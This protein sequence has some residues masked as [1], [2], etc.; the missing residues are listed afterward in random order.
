MTFRLIDYRSREKDESAPEVKHMKSFAVFS[1]ALILPFLLM[2]TVE[3]VSPTLSRPNF[4]VILVD[5]LGWRDCGYSGSEFYETPAINQL[6]KDSIQFTQA[7]AACPVCSPTRASIHTGKYPARLQT[8]EWFGGLQPQDVLNWNKAEPLQQHRLLPAKYRDFL[9]LEETTLAEALQEAGYDTFIAGK[10]HLGGSGSEPEK[11]G[12]RLNV[13]GY[14]K[15]WPVGGYF[16]PYNNP[17]LLDGPEGEHLPD[18]LS[19]ESIQFLQSATDAPFFLMLSFYSVHVP[20]E[21]PEEL[22]GK[23]EEKAE[24]AHHRGV[25]FA[26]EGESRC[27]QVQDNAVYASMVESVDTAI[28][29]VLRSVSDLGLEE[30]T[31]VFFLSDNGGLSTSEGFPTS[32]VPLRAGKGWLY[33]GGIRIPWLVKWPGV[34]SGGE[35]CNVPVI[36]NDLYPTVLEIA[37]L[38]LRPHQHVDACSLVPLLKDQGELTRT[39]LYW[40]YPHYSNQGGPPGGAIR[41]ADWKLIE[42]FETNRLELYNLRDDISEQKN[43]AESESD[44]VRAMHSKLQHWRKSVNAVMPEKNPRWEE[45]HAP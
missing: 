33:E 20:L 25:R 27:R 40:H 17:C 29:N 21:G 2:D 38:P 28:D 8:T 36:S 30:N 24:S 45:D 18:R 9:P 1:L 15:G 39:D 44:R 4:I 26:P 19:R 41:S 3:A 13:G 42:W 12:Y 10:W 37:G 14:D 43:L 31:I 35:S 32:N 7:Y 16:S 6:A 34:I 22:I 5:D 23:Y 11:H